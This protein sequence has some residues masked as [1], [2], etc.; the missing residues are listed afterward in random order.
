MTGQEHW[1]SVYS[2]K[3]EQGV[4]WYQPHATQSMETLKRAGLSATTA[5]IDIGGG[6]ST[7]VDDL[8]HAGVR[9]VTVLDLAPEALAVAQ[10]RLRSQGLDSA[11]AA[12]H[13]L[14][15]D[16]TAVQLPEHRY[17]VWHDRAVF[18]FLTDAP[19]RARYLEQVARAVRPGGLVL[20]ATF[21]EDGPERCSGLA[22]CRYNAAELHATFGERYRLISHER[23]IHATPWGAEQRFTWCLCRLAG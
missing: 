2:N 21:A 15:A 19:Q 12:V 6:A 4:S 20:V 11:A 18:H 8:W 1:R 9:D 14:E 7:L 17:D 10:Q 16:I 13:W 22:V 5:V 23:Q 3:G